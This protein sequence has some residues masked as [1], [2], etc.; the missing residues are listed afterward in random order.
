MP[1]K[2][3]IIGSFVMGDYENGLVLVYDD[4]HYRYDYWDMNSARTSFKFLNENEVELYFPDSARRAVIR[5]N[6]ASSV[7]VDF[8]AKLKHVVDSH[9]IESILLK[10]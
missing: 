4:N 7:D 5:N 1:N 3:N 6:S 2:P 10:D 9:A 8:F